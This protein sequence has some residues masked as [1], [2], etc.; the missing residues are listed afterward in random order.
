MLRLRSSSFSPEPVAPTIPRPRRA[1]FSVF[2]ALLALT[3]LLTAAPQITDFTPRSGPPGTVI[4]V[5]G[6]GFGTVPGELTARVG[7][8]TATVTAAADTSATLTAPAASGLIEF[9]LDGQSSRALLPFTL[10]RT[11]PGTFTPPAGFDAAGYSTGTLSQITAGN[12]FTL[13]A[14]ADAVGVAWAWRDARDPM[15]L[16]LVYPDST[17]VQ[18]DAASTALALVALSPLAPKG[19]PATLDAILDRAVASP[20][21]AAVASLISAASAA[22][23]A[24][25]DDGRF[26]AAHEALL[27]HAFTEPDPPAPLAA[28]FVPPGAG[29]V[30]PIEPENAI[31]PRRLDHVITQLSA[32]PPLQ[33]LT[34]AA[35]DANPTRL[36]Q[37][38]ELWRVNPAWFT[39]GFDHINRLA[40]TDRPWQLDSQPYASGFVNAELASAKLDPGEWIGKGVAYLLD[41]LTD[42]PST[43]NQFFLHRD[44]PGIYMLNAFSG[45]IWFGTNSLDP[46]RSQSFLISQIDPYGQWGGALTTNLLI[47]AVDVASIFL[48]E[49]PLLGRKELGEIAKSISV[50]LT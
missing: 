45:N 47:G 1:R 42:T 32:D 7:T 33:K 49:L 31:A 9:T 4:T 27:T 23:H 35:A 44:R 3:P 43:D 21:L 20:E 34:S 50:E 2:A 17:H 14:P 19:D 39:D 36:H 10:T 29:Y 28:S 48:P 8:T 5:Q 13:S 26:A 22:G 15:F 6:Q 37:N 12:S 41:G 40:I 16:A 38:L 46:G 24:Y 11:V 18:I 25:L 30:R